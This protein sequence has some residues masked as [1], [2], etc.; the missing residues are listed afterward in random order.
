MDT[1][2]L[3]APRIRTWQER[4]PAPQAHFYVREEHIAMQ[5]EIADL[6]AEVERLQADAERYQHMK[7]VDFTAEYCEYTS[8]RLNGFAEFDIDAAIA[9]SKEKA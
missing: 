7:A 9:A 5:A 4:L 8:N 6:R 1:E 3:K 2:K